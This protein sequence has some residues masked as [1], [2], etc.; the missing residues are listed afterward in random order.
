[1]TF[2]FFA[3][4]AILALTAFLSLRR[5]DQQRGPGKRMARGIAVFVMVLASVIALSECCTTIPAGHVGVIDIFGSVQDYTLKPGINF[6]NPLA[7][8]VKMS[9]QTQEAKET[10][11]TPSK[12][13]LAM[14]VE[15]S[16]LYH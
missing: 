8:I 11:D 2:A 14:Q 4:V 1:M 3:V 12:E 13:G 15:V 9:I 16:V 7:R 5:L 6:M 10:M